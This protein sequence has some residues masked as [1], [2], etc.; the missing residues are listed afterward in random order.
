MCN[1]EKLKQDQV[2]NAI[3]KHPMNGSGGTKKKG[4]KQREMDSNMKDQS[5]NQSE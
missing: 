4:R 3:G 5:S 2:P 1:Q